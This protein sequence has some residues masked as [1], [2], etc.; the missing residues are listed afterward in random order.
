MTLMYIIGIEN[1]EKMMKNVNIY[2]INLKY[3]LIPTPNL[4]NSLVFE[5]KKQLFF[6]F[7]KDIFK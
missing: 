5:V 4:L 6:R 7:F 3:K 2:F 1:I